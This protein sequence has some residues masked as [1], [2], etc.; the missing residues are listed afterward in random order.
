MYNERLFLKIANQ[1]YIPGLTEKE[2][3][4]CSQDTTLLYRNLSEKL[5]S[6]YAQVQVAG[7][8]FK[9]REYALQ[10]LLVDKVTM[11]TV[12][13]RN[14]QSLLDTSFHIVKKVFQNEVKTAKTGG[15]AQSLPSQRPHQGGVQVN[16]KMGPSDVLQFDN[17]M[18]TLDKLFDE[19]LVYLPQK[20]D[21]KV[22]SV[23]AAITKSLLKVI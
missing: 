22:V 18:D 2:I 20:I 12:L 13:W 17:V 10:P 5:M 15:P 23:M 4:A 3:N 8:V 14:I 16:R 9:I 21:L 19:R 7:N 1:I 11:V 6:R